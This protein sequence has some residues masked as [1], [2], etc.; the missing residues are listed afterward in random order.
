MQVVTPRGV[1]VDQTTQMIAMGRAPWCAFTVLPVEYWATEG[2]KVSVPV[3]LHDSASQGVRKITRTIA[4]CGASGG[5]WV[6]PDSAGGANA[7][8]NKRSRN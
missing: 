5:R 8:F 1:D 3:I 4:D 2:D 7:S 6:S